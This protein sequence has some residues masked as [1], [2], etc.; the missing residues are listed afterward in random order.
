VGS[1]DELRQLIDLARRERLP[2]LPLQARPLE[3]A[4]AALADL[5]A[6]KIVGRVVLRP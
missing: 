3:D 5:K 4:G 1:R 2:P 6:G